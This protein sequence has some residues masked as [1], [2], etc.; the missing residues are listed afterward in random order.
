MFLIGLLTFLGFAGRGRGVNLLI[1]LKLLCGDRKFKIV[2]QEFRS[3]YRACKAHALP[4]ELDA[5]D[6]YVDTNKHKIKML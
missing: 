5:L 4:I 3:P 2:R 6:V 1:T